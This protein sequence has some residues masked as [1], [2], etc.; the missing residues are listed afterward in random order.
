MQLRFPKKAKNFININK[1]ML[2]KDYNHKNPS[3][4][5][6]LGDGYFIK[7]SPPPDS[8]SPQPNNAKS[9]NLSGKFRLLK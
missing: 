4:V 5:K 2:A 1:T 8:R 3:S 6:N 9:R 7:M